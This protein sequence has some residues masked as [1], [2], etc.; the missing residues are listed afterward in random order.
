MEFREMKI[1]AENKKTGEIYEC[2]FEK[3]VADV[4]SQHLFMNTQDAIDEI[5]KADIDNPLELKDA[6]IWTEHVG[7]EIR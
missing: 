5:R 3:I 2:N 4:R 1:F 6:Y 7:D